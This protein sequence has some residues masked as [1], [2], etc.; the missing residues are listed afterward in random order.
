MSETG[1]Y[2]VREVAKIL[3][4]KK[5]YVYELLA[6]GRL[7]ALRLSER[8]IRIPAEALEEFV[9]QETARAAAK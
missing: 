1:T 9:R 3:R 8:R 6:Q 7:R 5:G 4:V 2:T